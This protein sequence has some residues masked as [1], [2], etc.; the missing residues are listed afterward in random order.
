MTIMKYSLLRAYTCFRLAWVYL[1]GAYLENLGMR[2]REQMQLATLENVNRT[3]NYRCAWILK[4]GRSSLVLVA[5]M[6]LQV[7]RPIH[8]QNPD[9]VRNSSPRRSAELTT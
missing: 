8:A 9:E 4:T 5:L 3:R 2:K 6:A 1:R 7:A